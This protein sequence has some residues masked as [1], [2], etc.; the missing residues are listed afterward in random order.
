LAR[1]PRTLDGEDRSETNRGEGKGHSIHSLQCLVLP[2][3]TATG[4]ENIPQH[5]R[6]FGTRESP[7]TGSPRLAVNPANAMLNYMYALLESEARLAAA[8]LGLDPGIGF[9]HVD[10]DARDSLACDLMEPVRPKVDAFL[11]GWISTQPLRREWFFEQRDGSCRLMAPFASR[12]SESAPAWRQQVAPIAEWVSRVLWATFKHGRKWMSAPTHLTQS[13]R[14]DAK[15][16]PH[17]PSLSLPQ[18]THLCRTCGKNA[19]R[20]Y[21]R[22]GSCRAAIST[23][24][25]V[26]AAF[27]GRL[28]SH[29]PDA[30]AKRIAGRRRHAAAIRAWKSTDQPE[31]L[32][33]EVYRRDIQSKLASVKLPTLM[34]AMGISKPY[35]INIRNGKRLPHPRHWL[36]L[37][38][39]VQVST[40]HSTGMTDKGSKTASLRGYLV[41][42]RASDARAR[43]RI[44]NLS[45]RF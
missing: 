18:P 45:K 43:M 14:R 11:L 31:W 33:E 8:A 16:K 7:I 6:T 3:N 39:L 17:P 4:P 26:E 21:E 22:C 1:R 25:L 30:T 19:T 32:T 13:K 24:R 44:S 20:G 9:L 28:L 37:A 40:C 38:E 42:I 12:L 15:G 36:R 27:K 34:A 5:W 41:G 10:T 35:A 29:L 23:E 2:T